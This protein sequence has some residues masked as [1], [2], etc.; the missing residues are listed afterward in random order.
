MGFGRFR[1][2]GLGGLG[3]GG[4]TVGGFRG[5]RVWGLVGLGFRGFR[6]WGL[7]F[8]KVSIQN[9][10]TCMHVYTESPSALMCSRVW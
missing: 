3:F 5:V 4:F 10:Y 1:V 6:V 7:G 9:V 8:R 2:W